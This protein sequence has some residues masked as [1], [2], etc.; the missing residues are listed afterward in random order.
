MQRSSSFTLKEIL[1]EVA[2]AAPEP[3]A[4][5][6][7]SE[8]RAEAPEAVPPLDDLSPLPGPGTPYRAHSRASNKPLN[9]LVLLLADASARGFAYGNLDTLDLVPGPP[10][11]GPEIVLRFAG[12]AAV[13]VTLAGRR[14]EALYNYLGLY[15]IGWVRQLPR[16]RDFQPSD[17]TVITDVAIKKLEG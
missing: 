11:Q 9:F 1:D 2:D 14:L 8:A 10:G 17:A 15:R 3:S 4:L 13:E 6:R 7:P 5:V 16:S 12:L